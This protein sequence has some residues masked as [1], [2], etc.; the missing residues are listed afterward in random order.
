MIRPPKTPAV[1][2]STVSSGR[3]KTSAPT[4]GT[5]S[6]LTGLDAIDRNASTCSVTAMLPSSAV[7]P[8]P[9]RPATISAA[10]TGPSSRTIDNAMM[11][12]TNVCPPYLPREYAVWIAS[13]MPVNSRVRFVMVSDRTPR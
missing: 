1:I 11:S 12:P 6:F 5:T 7:I 9:T 10:R 2:A 13:T 3:M 4:R 8:A